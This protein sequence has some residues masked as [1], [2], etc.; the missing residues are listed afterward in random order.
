[1]VDFE[2]P[3]ED[4]PDNPDFL[5]N[6]LSDRE[7][8]LS[9]RMFEMNQFGRFISD[10][11]LFDLRD[12]GIVL[13][14]Y[15]NIALQSALK[16]FHQ[17]PSVHYT[18]EAVAKEQRIQSLVKQLKAELGPELERDEEATREFWGDDI[19]PEDPEPSEYLYLGEFLDSLDLLERC[20]EEHSR[21]LETAKTLD[22]EPKSNRADRIRYFYWLIL[23]AFW[24]FRLKREIKTSSNGENEG[25]GPLVRF[26]QVMSKGGGSEFNES[27]GSA[28]RQWIL[29]N[30]I[31]AGRLA[32]LF[33]R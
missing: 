22:V 26:I 20:S 29:R 23:L 21:W 12:M 4:N 33:G 5:N 9:L 32:Y 1:M 13:S 2:P 6:P 18:P 11:V 14:R 15:D 8:R 7:M 25:S 19:D 10:D 3:W 17:G 31:Q 27:N 28:V 30:G 24:K 16:T